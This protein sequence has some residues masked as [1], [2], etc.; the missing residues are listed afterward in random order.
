[1]TSNN[2]AISIQNVKKSFGAL[3][4]VNGVNLTIN[5]GEYVAMLGPNGAGKTTLMEMVEGIQ[6]QDEGDIII[7]GKTWKDH[8]EELHK[9]LGISLQETHFFDKL[10]VKETVKLFA[11]FYSIGDGRCN[12]ILDLVNLQEK[13]EAF[14]INLSG[15]QR[16]R[17]ALGIALINN[18]EII[19]LDEPTT[20]LDPTARREIW[21]ILFKLKKE[22]N[23]TMILTTHYMEEADYLCD[24]IVILDKGSIL[25]QGTLDEL[26]SKNGSSEIIEFSLEGDN[27]N[28]QLPDGNGKKQLNYDV[29]TEKWQL[30]VDDIIAY[31][32]LFLEE[33]KKQN[34]KIKTLECRKMTLDDLFI[35]MTGRRL[36]E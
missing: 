16:Q 29:K 15:G 24:R 21:D 6:H 13:A 30:L 26:L 28:V 3:K 27:N 12:E 35:A 31:L 34:K 14:V 7:N 19:L 32:P 18:P 20:G 36:N 8:E 25:A 23:I 9:L 2:I 10:K 22:K 11:S 17:L 4:A 5:K 1:M 33:M